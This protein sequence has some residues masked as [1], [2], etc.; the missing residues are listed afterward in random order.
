MKN[1]KIIIALFVIG[2]MNVSCSDNDALNK[3]TDVIEP[4]ISIQ[5]PIVNQTYVGHWGGAWPEADK[6]ILK[7]TG[8]DETLIESMK[9]TVLNGKGVSV[10]E[11]IVNTTVS[12]QTELFI[13]ESFQPTDAGIYSVIVTVTDM[14]GNSKVSLPRTFLV[15]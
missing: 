14:N 7:A 13:A 11:K 5:S 9:L 3:I 2:F 6:V 4:I 10:F 12:N 1:Y 15:K 8:K